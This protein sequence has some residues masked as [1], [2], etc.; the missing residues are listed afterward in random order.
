MSETSKDIKLR[1]FKSA[2][3]AK[4]QKN[5]C[6]T[7]RNSKDDKCQNEDLLFNLKGRVF[8]N[9]NLQRTFLFFLIR[10]KAVYTYK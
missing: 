2:A 6:S 1:F 8:C 10:M 3:F 4:Y 5:D 9:E 7:K